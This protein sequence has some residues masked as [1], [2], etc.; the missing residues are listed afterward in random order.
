MAQQQSTMEIQPPTG[1]EEITVEIK[2]PT[3]DEERT[4][5]FGLDSA[6]VVKDPELSFDCREAYTSDCIEELLA[7]ATTRLSDKHRRR[8]SRTFV[9]SR[10]PTVQAGKRKKQRVGPSPAVLKAVTE[11]GDLTMKPGYA[12]CLA[13]TTDGEL[14]MYHVKDDPAYVDVCVN[15]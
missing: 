11:S 2:P 3:G 13:K 12:R 5:T 1:D 4:W 15:F 14:F 9:V 10:L 6:I 7:V 8:V